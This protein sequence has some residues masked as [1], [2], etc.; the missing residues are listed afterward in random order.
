MISCEKK[1]RENLPKKYKENR[2]RRRDQNPG[3][4]YTTFPHKTD[5]LRF[6]S[7]NC[8]TFVQSNLPTLEKN[9]CGKS[10]VENPKREHKK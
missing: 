6:V 9:M 7:L 2:P 3:Y 5:I 10:P 4:N 8:A 1:E